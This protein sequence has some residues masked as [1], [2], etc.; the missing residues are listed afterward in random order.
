M[1]AAGYNIVAAAAKAATFFT[2][3]NLFGS[4][5]FHSQKQ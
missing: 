3:Y 5:F 4:I 1:E 2:S